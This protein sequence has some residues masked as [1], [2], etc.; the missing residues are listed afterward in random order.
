MH[1]LRY[2]QVHLDFHTHGAIPDVGSKFQRRQFQEALRR[3]H[4][5]SVTIFAKCHHGWSYHPTKVGRRHPTLTFDLLKRQIEACRAI[6]VRCPIYISAGLDE[7]MAEE[8]PEWLMRTRAGETHP[9]FAARWK[10][11]NFNSAYLDYLCRQIEEVVDRWP[12]HDGIFLDIIHATPDYSEPSLREMRQLGLDPEN[13]A[14]AERHAQMVVRRYFERTTAIVRQNRPDAPI[15]H[16]SGHISLG[17]RQLLDYN[18]HLELES[19]PTGGWGYDHFPLSA[20]YAITTGHDFLGMTGKFHTTWGEFGGFKRPAALRYECGGMLAYGAKCSVGDQLHPNGEMNLDTYALI[21]QAYAEVESKEAWCEGVLPVARI[22]I[23]SAECAQDTLRRSTD[24][25]RSDEGAA[26][27]LLELHQ[28]FVVLDDTSPWTPYDL[29]IL[30]DSYRMTPP[31]LRKA[32]TCLNRGGKLLAAGGALLDVSGQKFAIDPGARLLGRS[33]CDPCYLVATEE[34]GDVPVRAPIVVHGGAWLVRPKKGTR[35]LAERREPYFNRSW[36]HF[37][38]H[39]HAPDAPGE[40]PGPG[41]IRSTGIA[42]FAHDIFSQYR[43]LGQPLYRDF[44]AAAMR[45]LLGHLPVLTSLP[46]GGRINVLHQRAER[47]FV[48]HLM[49]AVTAVRGEFTKRDRVQPIEVIEDTV[50][51]HDVQ[52]MVRLPR[53]PKRARLVPDDVNLPFEISA[54]RVSFMV[55]KVEGHQMVELAY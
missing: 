13:L 6:D 33:E 54:D 26:R 23:A 42:W 22:A 16:N 21:G 36:K 32:K 2:R 15:F 40:A 53:R 38:S 18:S 25:N 30:P 45:S 48:V 28:P 41:A 39:Q 35:I 20:R 46:T 51:L 34:T 10:R 9:P 44:I 5:D 49:F 12:D 1:R 11:L 7:L 43:Q 4:V 14:D 24:A 17:A 19:L 3:G 29:V 50:P 27:M 37:C 52:V 55:P 8:H 47:R 31:R